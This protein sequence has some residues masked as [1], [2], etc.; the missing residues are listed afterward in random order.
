MLL[1]SAIIFF[2]F[3]RSVLQHSVNSINC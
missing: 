2:C 1:V 3:I